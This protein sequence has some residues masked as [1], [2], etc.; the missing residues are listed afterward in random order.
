MQRSGR[1]AGLALVEFLQRRLIRLAG[2][3][4]PVLL[5][6]LAQRGRGARPENP[7]DG[8]DVESFTLLFRSAREFFFAPVIEHGPLPAWK[9]T[10]GKGEE[11]QDVFWYIKE[12]IDA[13]F[14]DRAFA[15]TVV[16]GCLRGIKRQPAESDVSSPVVRVA[17]K[18]E[19][20]EVT[21]GQVD[22]E[23]VVPLDDDSGEEPL[24]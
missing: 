10:A 12:A 18:V 5:L 19:E 9:E 16:A 20:I 6:K 1:E 13:Y 7:V 24:E 11:M 14:R 8:S 3:S 17:P 4:E 23:S 22:I 15:V 2:S 21:T